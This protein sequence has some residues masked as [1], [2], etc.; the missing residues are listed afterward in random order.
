MTTPTKFNFK[1]TPTYK[2]TKKAQIITRPSFLALTITGNG[3]PNQPGF[4][5]DI[6]AIY[7]LAYGI[8]MRFKKLM[9]NDLFGMN[10]FEPT[11]TDYV[12]P[13]LS[14][15]WTIS[16]S[17]QSLGAWDKSDLVYRLELV[18]PD[19]VPLDFI[20]ASIEEIK[21]DKATENPRLNDVMLATLPAETVAHILHVG[22][23]DDEP[24]TFDKMAVFTQSEGY[25]RTSKEHRELY[26]SDARRTTPEKLKTIL[27]VSVSQE[28]Q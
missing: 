3:D 7:A 19:E 16:E 11:I 1:K 25:R 27:E 26:L 20:H 22:S 10:L 18:I 17:A 23:Y 5:T 12:V 6:Q 28:A 15:Y 24:E 13:P 9:A 14:G 2:A 4:Q 21:A 8:K